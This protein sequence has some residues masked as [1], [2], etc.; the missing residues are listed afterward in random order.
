[1][2]AELIAIGAELLLGEISDTNTAHMA[3]ALREV[4]V[5]VR[6][7]TIV[8]D[9]EAQVAEVL[10]A[11]AAR[12]P[13]VITTGGLG[14]TVDDPTR[15]AYARAFGL[16]LEFRD[17]LWAQIQARFARFKRI[18]TENNKQQALVPVGAIAFENPVGTAPCFAV[19]HAGGVALALPGVP[20]E[21]EMMLAHALIPYLQQKF[22]LTHLIRA[23]VLRTVGLGE[24]MID[25]QIGHL[26]RL[27][28]PVVGLAAHAGQTDIRITAT[29]ASPEAAEALIAPVEAEIRATLGEAVY[30]EG[31]ESVEEVVARLLA[32]RGQTCGIAER[33]TSGAEYGTDGHLTGRVKRLENQV[34]R[35]APPINT[36]P[37]PPVRP[38]EQLAAHA[39]TATQADWGLGVVVRQDGE[40]SFLE[41]ALAGA[42]K[43]EI[44]ELGFGTHPALAA[45]WAATNALN[46]LRLTLLKTDKPERKM[47]A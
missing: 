22:S 7:F 19:E 27:T 8:G 38:A 3:R 47:I 31:K 25:E 12:A 41:I 32:A 2:H 34:F 35:P 28:N 13:I 11:A 21:M 37:T 42:H 44:R 39:R 1:M 17:E 26:E 30:G 46:L 24:S 14:P 29:A 10:A 23:K 40:H 33:G 36:N 16:P 45:R 43:I 15:A 20:R 18:P 5:P 4:G 6:L 9:D